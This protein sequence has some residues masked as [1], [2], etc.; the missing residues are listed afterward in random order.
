MLG[1]KT[2]TQQE[3]DDATTGI[4]Q[5]LKA[6]KKLVQAIDTSDPKVASALAAFEPLFS[7]N[8]TLALDRRFVHRLRGVTGKDGTP[9]N[10]VEL[11]ADSLMNNGGVLRGNNVI[12]LV[13]EQTVLKLEIGDPIRLSAAEFERLADA[14]LAEI[15]AKYVT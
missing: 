1:R 2:F 8:L 6:Y 11:M 4:D 13:P 9:L 7:N 3:L 12:K 14:F 5:Q 15:R 10:E